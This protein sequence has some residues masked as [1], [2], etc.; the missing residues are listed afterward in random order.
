MLPHNCLSMMGLYMNRC[1][2]KYGLENV[3]VPYFIVILYECVSVWSLILDNVT[4]PSDLP[5][6]PFQVNN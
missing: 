2:S 4:L 5:F 3:D 6:V 1:I